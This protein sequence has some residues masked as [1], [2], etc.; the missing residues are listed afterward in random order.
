MRTDSA[1]GRQ[2]TLKL[3]DTSATLTLAKDLCELGRLLGWAPTISEYY[4]LLVDSQSTTDD[5]P[6]NGVS[7]THKN[8]IHAEGAEGR[9]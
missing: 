5:K 1:I 3:E 2:G 9:S 6:T 8:S 7:S 4:S